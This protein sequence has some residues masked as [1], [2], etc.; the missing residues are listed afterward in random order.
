MIQFIDITLQFCA[1]IRNR[2]IQ[3]LLF[4]Y[5]KLRN[6]ASVRYTIHQST[7]YIYGQ[8]SWLYIHVYFASTVLLDTVE[9]DRIRLTSSQKL[10]SELIIAVVIR[11]QTIRSSFFSNHPDDTTIS[12]PASTHALSDSSRP[13]TP[14]VSPEK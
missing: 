5:K 14:T 10:R 7:V 11:S 1:V 3:V 4:I 9:C 12:R 8:Q 13:R 2:I 6:T